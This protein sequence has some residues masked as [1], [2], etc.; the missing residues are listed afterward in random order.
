MKV[1]LEGT[2]SSIV[3]KVSGKKGGA[4]VQFILT[5]GGSIPQ[6]YLITAFLDRENENEIEM[7]EG[8]QIQVDCYLN[9]K[10]FTNGEKKFYNELKLI[11]FR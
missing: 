9:G 7:R 3:K 2:L 11:A 4:I 10:Q 8:E 6:Q 1:T 5:K